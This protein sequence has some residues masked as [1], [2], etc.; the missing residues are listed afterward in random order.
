M[1][2]IFTPARGVSAHMMKL[3]KFH[4]VSA[5]FGFGLPVSAVQASLSPM[6]SLL[7]KNAAILVTMDEHRREIRDGGFYG[8]RDRDPACGSG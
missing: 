7:V 5:S 2:Q 4:G 3:K 8:R 6:G 1:C